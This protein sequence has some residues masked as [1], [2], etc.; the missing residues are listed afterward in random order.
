[1]LIYHKLTTSL[2]MY[3]G[4]NKDEHVFNVMAYLWCIFRENTFQRIHNLFE[5]IN[6][7][8]GVVFAIYMTKIYGIFILVILD[9]F[10]MVFY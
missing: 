8:F 9:L 6:V 1:M 10:Y 7:L 5:D 3:S 4:S 2:R